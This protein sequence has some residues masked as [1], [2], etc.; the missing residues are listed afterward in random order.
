MRACQRRRSLSPRWPSGQASAPVRTAAPRPL[1]C[2]GISQL[3]ATGPGG[4]RRA[5]YPARRPG[6][7]H[8]RRSGR[9]GPGVGGRGRAG[10]SAPSDRRCRVPSR[11]GWDA[12]GRRGQARAPPRSRSVDPPA[13]GPAD[14]PSG[15]P[16]GGA[17]RLF[18]RE[19][20]AETV[21]LGEHPGRGGIAKVRG[22]R[23][24]PRGTSPASVPSTRRGINRGS[25][26]VARHMGCQ[27]AGATHAG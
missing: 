26:S 10:Q 24:R 2:A 8:R 4:P 11:P 14:P 15:L 9:R 6:T 25:P 1:G 23:C 22:R 27:A 16:R 13:A 7:A 21:A 5:R 18:R 12:R 3:P 20:V 19:H 17:E